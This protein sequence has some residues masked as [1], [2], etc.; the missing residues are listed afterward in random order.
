[1]TEKEQQTKETGAMTDLELA[2]ELANSFQMIP[3]MQENIRILLQEII[4]RKQRHD[5]AEK[6]LNDDTGKT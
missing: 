5:A 4:T 3:K 2:I 6:G 1:M